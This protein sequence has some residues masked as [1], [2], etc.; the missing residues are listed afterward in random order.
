[1]TLESKKMKIIEKVIQAENE[2]SLDVILNFIKS[3]DKQQDT[4][5]L[6]NGFIVEPISDKFDIEKIKQEQEKSMEKLI[7]SWDDFDHSAFEDVN[8][9]ELM[10]DL[11]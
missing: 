6:E 1:M 8:W 3:S 4:F 10:K 5:I 7:Q 2:K 9:E 11:D